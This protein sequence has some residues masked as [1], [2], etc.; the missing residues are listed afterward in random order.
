MAYLLIRLA[1]VYPVS[2]D[3]TAGVINGLLMLCREPLFLMDQCRKKRLEAMCP[4]ET[5]I[6]QFCSR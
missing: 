3:R 1:V 6:P 2:S 5:K 4:I